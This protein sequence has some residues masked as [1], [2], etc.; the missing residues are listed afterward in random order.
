VSETT[1]RSLWPGADAIGQIVRLDRDPAEAARDGEP[2]VAS[3]TFTVIGVARDV[4][5]FRMMPLPKAVVYLPGSDAMRGTALV[6]R[7]RGEPGRARE[8]LLARLT[9][10]DPA[11]AQGGMES[12]G[13]VAWVTKMETYLLQLGFWLT[14]VLGG[15][16]L[17]LT[18]SGL[19]SVLSYLVEQ[20][21][22]EIGVRMALGA[23]RTW[24]MRMILGG[25]FGLASA[26]LALGLAGAVALSRTSAAF[27]YETSPLDPLTFLAV[28]AVI[29]IISIAASAV[30]A[31][32]AATIDP[33]TA[34]RVD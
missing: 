16:A 18:V 5:G 21:T 33:V 26:G 6:A 19:F 3:R 34:L 11:L 28:A 27:L 7:V 12:V 9:A 15:L 8:A 25:A 2:A 29:I 32:R 17:A 14:V 13:A 30:P 4:P 23:T 24:V 31:R 22:R 1:A 20:R 10:I